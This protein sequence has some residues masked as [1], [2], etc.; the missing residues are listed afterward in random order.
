[1]NIENFAKTKIGQLIIRIMASIMESRFR[2]RLFEPIKII[3]GA[4]IHPSEDVLEVGCGTGFFTVPIARFLGDK[5][6]LTS[7]DIL[8]KSI[9]KVSKKIQ[10]AKLRNVRVFKDD[11]LNIQLDSESM[12]VIILFGVIPSPVLPLNKLLAE[13]HRVL[14]PGGKMSVWP[15]I[16]VHK[17][18]I[19]SKLFLFSGKRNNVLTYKRF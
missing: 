2:Y 11:A 12:D 10:D 16:M 1:M 7:I 5:G 8:P 18:I 3:Q 13:M 15:P 14:K 19:K 6:S 17:S 9:E 4:A